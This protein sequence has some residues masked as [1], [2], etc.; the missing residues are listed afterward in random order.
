MATGHAHPS[1]GSAPAAAH[2]DD[3]GTVVADVTAIEGTHGIWLSGRLRPGVTEQQRE[4]LRAAALSGDWRRI[5]GGLEL[6]AALAVNVPGFPVPRVATGQR[7]GRQ[8]ALVAS[9]VVSHVTEAVADER[10]EL[11]AAVLAEVR[12]ATSRRRRADK[13]ARRIARD[14]ESRRMAAMAAVHGRGESDRL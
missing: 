12:A 8:T 13:A 14:P 11:T 2:Y 1:L 4:A 3:T 7:G 10:H 6:V 5:R 9:G